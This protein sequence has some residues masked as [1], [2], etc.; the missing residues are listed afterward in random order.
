[1]RQVNSCILRNDTP[2]VV[3]P[4][5][6]IEITDSSLSNFDGEVAIE[7]RSDFPHPELWPSPSISRVIQG[8]VRIPNLG[9]EPIRLSKSQHIAQI[10]RVTTPAQSAIDV[11]SP[12]VPSIVPFPVVK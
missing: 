6:F 8:T 12:P 10:R 3:L 7:P 5:E 4:G 11:S 9:H 1:M 2:Q